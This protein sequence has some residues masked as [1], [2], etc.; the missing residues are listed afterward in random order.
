MVQLSPGD[1]L[2]SCLIIYAVNFKSVILMMQVY[3]MIQKKVALKPHSLQ[4]KKNKSK[5][6]K[7][8]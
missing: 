6:H 7:D 2:S 1:E 3:H 4:S 8:A 5:K